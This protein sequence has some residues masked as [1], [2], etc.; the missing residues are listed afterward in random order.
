MALSDGLVTLWEF[1][2]ASAPFLDSIGSLNLSN[3]GGTPGSTIGK[4]GN[5][6]SLD[7]STESLQNAGVQPWTGIDD[8]TFS[9]WLNADTPGTGNQ[10]VATWRDGAP[11][12]MTFFILNSS[13]FPRV[14]I[15][16]ALANSYTLIGTVAITTGW[17]LFM[18]QYVRNDNCYMWVDNQATPDTIANIDQPLYSPTTPNLTV[19]SST[20]PGVFYD[21]LVD[22]FA[23]WNRALNS[24]ERAQVYNSG[25][26]TSL[27]GQAYWQTG[28]PRDLGIIG[29]TRSWA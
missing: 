13:A 5:A 27:T 20:A 19:G 24:A 10:I 3:L 7:G 6:L 4:I 9:C 21:G 8:M 18:Y 15:F 29:Y 16:D 23:I 2:E 28:V 25:N 22:Q 26:G 14:I 17:H 1:E 12:A 11:A